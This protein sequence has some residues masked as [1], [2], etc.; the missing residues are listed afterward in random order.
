MLEQSSGPS[1]KP[2]WAQLILR[3]LF[4]NLQPFEIHF[5]DSTVCSGHLNCD[6][7]ITFK[8]HLLFFFNR[9]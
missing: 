3:E 2:P 8:I 4:L 7:L 1:A 5:P 6:L 9:I